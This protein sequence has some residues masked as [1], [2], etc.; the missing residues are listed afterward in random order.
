MTLRLIDRSTYPAWP[1]QWPIPIEIAH[2]KQS[3]QTR[4]TRDLNRYAEGQISGR[5]YLIAG[6][7][8]AGKSALIHRA[9]EAV[10]TQMIEQ[11]I[12]EE[13]G[14]LTTR[15]FQRPLLVKLHGPSML[16]PVAEQPGPAAKSKTEP[17]KAVVNEGKE[18]LPP[19]GEDM[20]PEKAGVAAGNQ[21]IPPA[22]GVHAALVQITIGL[23]RALAAEAAIGFR[24][25]ARQGEMERRSGLYPR[26][27]RSP[28]RRGMPMP[29]PPHSERTEM[30][31]DAVELSAQLTLELDSGL[32]PTRLREFWHRLGRV[33]RG[34]L[35]PKSADP[36]LQACTMGDQGLR[37]MVAIATASQAF[38]V[39]TGR[40]SYEATQKVSDAR[41]T[42]SEIK[43]SSDLKDVIDRLGTLGVG[44]LAGV[45][46]LGATG[47]G[48]IAAIGTGL[49][50]WFLGSLTANWSRSRTRKD[51]HTVD[52]S[53]IRES[54]RT[55]LDRDLPVVISRLREAGLSP[56]FVVDELDKVDDAANAIVD[57]LGHL[58]HLVADFGFFCFL[59]DRPCFLEFQRRTD[60]GGYPPEHTLFSERLL[61]TPEFGPLYNFLLASVAS[62]DNSEQLEA[63]AVFA[64]TTIHESQMNLTNVMRAMTRAVRDDDGS[65]GAETEYQQQRRLVI[66]TVQIAIIERLRSSA[67][68][69]RVANNPAFAQMAIDTLYYPSSQW[70]SGASSV[71]PTPQKLREHLLKQ[72]RA[73]NREGEGKKVALDV[74]LSIPESDLVD[75]HRVLVGLLDDLK[76]D[77]DGKLSN[78]RNAARHHRLSG[79]AGA[80]VG[81]MPT[82]ADIVPLELTPIVKRDRGQYHFQF[83]R[84][85]EPVGASD[86]K[87]SAEEAARARVL[88]E[89]AA[90]FEEVIGK[91]G[92]TIDELAETPLLAGLSSVAVAQA[93]GNLENATDLDS[94][95]SDTLQHLAT[96]DR[97]SA[98]IARNAAKLSHLLV[99][100]TYLRTNKKRRGGILPVIRRMLPLTRT[101][102]QWLSEFAD[103]A[104]PL[105]AEAIALKAWGVE[106]LDKIKP[107][108]VKRQS[109]VEDFEKSSTM[110][111]ELILEKMTNERFK[112]EDLALAVAQKLPYRALAIDSRNMT[113]QDWSDLALAAL[114]TAKAAATAPYWV[115]I[116][117]LRALGFGAPALPTLVDETEIDDLT[118]SKFL[119][120]SA[121]RSAT[122]CMQFA[123]RFTADIPSRP[124]G[125]VVF[126][127]NEE[128]YG[129][130]RPSTA[131]PTLVIHADQVKDYIPALNWLDANDILSLGA[132]ARVAEDQTDES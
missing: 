89:L 84:T 64:L 114:P 53:F 35:W 106:V 111:E 99:I 27:N 68:A 62:D 51:D 82:F 47:A 129:R 122:E 73:R 112:L 94:T 56:V 25:H 92:T 69:D 24:A 97:L 110:I 81:D 16:L 101:P 4:L 102:R 12:R 86:Q 22:P 43:G 9:V 18:K 36:T 67:I 120:L 132:D 20:S 11:A 59:V 19:P 8:G 44:A 7:R 39:C 48:P 46:V 55:T 119:L 95:T 98:E 34:V 70:M 2:V 104:R 32:G 118:S 87:L 77:K 83:T 116:G 49:V 131:R 88:L 126:D 115:L 76:G 38:E 113:A 6:H 85:G 10:R 54:D 130:A 60:A 72:I 50:T 108:A 52:Y 109:T 31:L 13:G 23:Y 79:E 121:M 26:S 61:L 80:P 37:E 103:K 74:E 57:L 5:S 128:R 3:A 45:T 127:T 29:M 93:R 107:V 66:A 14:R 65:I 96:L 17:E 123:E 63:R 124:G 58:K 75:L 1:D 30:T 78:V 90:A 71:H 41:T 28:S 125:T 100:L 91:A 15:P 105:P 21:T 33:Q 117:A 40:V 42:T